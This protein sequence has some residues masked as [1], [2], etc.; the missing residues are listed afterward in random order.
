MRGSS[1]VS[2]GSRAVVRQ[3]RH[4]EGDV[5]REGGVSYNASGELPPV[6]SPADLPLAAEALRRGDLV[7]MPT[8]TVYG[9]A[10]DARYP[11]S[12]SR[13]FSAKGREEGKP[14][15]LL[16]SSIRVVEQYGG[17]FGSTERRL[18][19][20]FWPGPLT[21]VLRV[22]N[23]MEGFRV[24]AC[25]LALELVGAAGGMLRVTSA[26]RSGDPPARRAADAVAVLGSV[27]AAAVDGGASPGG[28]PSTVVR[29]ERDGLRVLRAG[30]IPKWRIESCGV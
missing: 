29:V 2:E 16:A 4:R 25:A 1:P 14:I 17:E 11:G 12:Q 5:E 10:A 21:L 28:V 23:T 13:L 27:V 22:G 20:R 26:N 8:D 18:A 9:L 3:P 15:P 19:E 24:P 7:V 30:A 6:L